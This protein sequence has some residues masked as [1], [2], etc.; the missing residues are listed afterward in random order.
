[1]VEV[2][3]D[4]SA[5]VIE[6]WVARYNGPGNY[7]DYARDIAVDSS[8]NVYVTGYSTGSGTG[9]DYTILVYDSSGNEL[10]VARYNGPGNGNDYAVS[11]ALGTSGN[12][13]VTGYSMGNGTGYDYAT[14]AY[15]SS[16]NEVWVARYNGPSNDSDVAQEIA[17]DS[18]ENVHVTGRSGGSGTDYDYATIKYDLY[19]N[20][21]WVK[22]YDGPVSE[23]DM[24][25]AIALDQSGN[26]YVTGNSR[27]IGTSNDYATIK[28]DSLGNEL[29]VTRYNGPVNGGDWA[30][31]IALDSLG[32]VYVTGQ[33]LGS[34]TNNDY[35]TI[36]YN[37]SGNELWVARYDGPVNSYDEAYAIALDS[38]GNIYVTGAS[39]GSGTYYDYATIAYD[40]SGNEL[41]VVRYNGPGNGPDM[42]KAIALDSSNN[43]YVIGYSD[44]GGIIADYAT[45]AYD[46]L[47][48]ELWVARYNGPGN[49]DDQ[50]HGI[51]L[52]SSGNVYVTGFSY[53]NGTN[54]DYATIKYSQAFPNQPPVADAGPDQTVNEGDV[55][56]LDGTGSYD[57]EG[58]IVTYQWD[59][60]SSDGLWWDTSAAP[61]ATGPNPTHTYGDDGVYVA[62][63]R[64]TDND[65]LSATDICNITVLNVNPTVEIEYAIMQVEIGLRVAGRKFNDVGM[66]LSENENIV[67]YVSI[68]RFPGSPD[69]QMAW[70]PMTLDM[71]KTYS[72]FVTFTPED[73]PN[74][75]A[76][77]T[78]IYI[79]F[80]NGSIKKIHH[81]FNV[82]QSKKRD[83]D[84]WNHIEPW[85]VDLSSNFIGLPFEIT[86]H[87]TD[88]GSDDEYLV[89][90]YGSRIVNVTYLNNPPNPDPY[91]S[92]EVKPREIIDIT[93]LS[94]EGPGTL[95]LL[96]EDDDVGKTT[97]TI[98]LV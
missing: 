21:Q 28:Y 63:L 39:W 22:R 81:T 54:F 71:T 13:Y 35:V 51:A 9:N 66:T 62:T 69:D 49:F 76:N 90:T 72:A 52:D 79:K 26:I 5:Q 46:S 61:D 80:P 50:A 42:A 27:G 40:S 16:G 86:S 67:G 25:N 20:E 38:S 58:T 97:A 78:W 60:D 44:G 85:K 95:T 84:H 48:N 75:G 32:Y 73:P 8:G 23:S 65:N 2:P 7:N 45:I 3:K 12:V 31:A 18:S 91:P 1:M 10:W 74:V 94:Y 43:I 88:P 30:W 96:V 34:G 15:D 6:E 19:G 11:I 47:G 56:D 82:Q 14:V 89:Y 83:S 53:G 24:A 17:V 93:T 59:F 41:W 57:P 68:E 33:S 37:S 70:I 55:V 36:A 29:W 77:P 64:V 87:I 98:Y 92:P 4:V